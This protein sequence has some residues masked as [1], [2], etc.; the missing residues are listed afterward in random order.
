MNT[1]LPLLLAASVLASTVS[2]VALAQTDA[3]TQDRAQAGCE[4][5][6]T[7]ARDNEERFTAEWIDE[8]GEVIA[9]GNDRDCQPYVE[10]AREA[11]DQLE[12]QARGEQVDDERF[13]AEQQASSSQIIVSQPEPQVSVEQQAPE[14]AVSQP[15][16]QV[17]VNQPQPEIIVRQAQPTV[18]IEMPRPVVTID[19][20]EPEIIVRMPDPEVAVSTADPEVDVSQRQPEVE[21]DQAQPQVRVEMEEPDVAVEERDQAEVEVE[22]DQAVVRQ[23]AGDQQADIN[24]SQAEPRVSY[25]AAE[26]NVEFEGG[27][28]P[29][30]RYNANNEA[31]VQY[32]GD[33]GDQASAADQAQT[34]DT[35]TGAMNQREG[36]R[37]ADV[38]RMSADDLLESEIYGANDE[39]IGN[40]S[41]V[42]LSPE[43]E[44]DALLV[45]AGGFLGIGSKEVAIGFDNVEIMQD[46]EDSWY[47]YTPYTEEQIDDHPEYDALTYAEQRDEQR[48]QNTR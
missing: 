36:M 4:A 26:P 16:P 39:H 23:E 41:D 35:M 28:E 33:D 31:N 5:L 24:V 13:S 22:Q 6:E 9:R 21:V 40:V 15:Q 45:D 37:E 3:E 14:V 30:V 44:I 8:A 1:K 46:A 19:Q 32:E 25:E 2:T 42:I 29:E 20:P 10:Q 12:R 38:E 47:V 18:T 11:A 7:L 43:G 17:D 34:D 48:L 27:G